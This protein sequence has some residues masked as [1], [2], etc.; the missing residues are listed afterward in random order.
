MPFSPLFPR[1]TPFGR[2]LA[3]TAAAWGLRLQWPSGPD[4]WSAPA[5]TRLRREVRLALPTGMAMAGPRP[6]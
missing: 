5:G 2:V 3:T 4:F 1:S 6:L